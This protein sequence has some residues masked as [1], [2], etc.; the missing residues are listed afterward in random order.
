MWLLFGWTFALDLLGKGSLFVVGLLFVTLTTWP[1]FAGLLEHL[2]YFMNLLKVHNLHGVQVSSGLAFA[3]LP[4]CRF[5]RAAAALT[6][7]MPKPG[8]AYRFSFIALRLS[9][10]FL[11]TRNLVGSQPS[12]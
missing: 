9:F 7:E 2:T 4:I 1:G 8:P 6:M 3:W 10:V 5:V 11:A 12:P